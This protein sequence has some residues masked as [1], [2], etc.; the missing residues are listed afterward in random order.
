MPVKT[1]LAPD[2]A[3]FHRQAAHLILESCVAA[4]SERGRFSI[5]LSGG[6]TPRKLFSLLAESYSRDRMA[7]D[8]WHVFWG[9]ERCVP[10][11]HEDSNYRMANELLLSKVPVPAPQIHRIRGEMES[12]QDAARAYE[13]ELRLFFRNDSYPAF[14]VALQ[15]VG[16]DGHTASLFPGASVLNEAERWVAAVNHSGVKVPDRVTLTLPVLNAARRILV[17]CAGES[18]A[19]IVHNIF[20]GNGPARYPVQRLQPSGGGELIWLL[21][22]A[23]ASRLSGEAKFQAVHL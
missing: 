2:E 15:G 10:P 3:G 23:A 5:A 13:Q 9:D 20:Q 12:P 22:K 7:W 16:D 4:V 1:L 17:L 18:K 11:D 6:G 21:D 14:D 19:A 8:R